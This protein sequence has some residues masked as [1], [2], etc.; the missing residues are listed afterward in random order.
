M[1]LGNLSETSR[2]PEYVVK[3]RVKDVITAISR[4]LEASSTLVSEPLTSCYL[5][6]LPRH[7]QLIAPINHTVPLTLVLQ[8][9]KN[10]FSQ[11][12]RECGRCT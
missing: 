9:T 3:R 10:N 2:F 4:R 6:P 8:K 1:K 11:V 12:A 7:I 5:V